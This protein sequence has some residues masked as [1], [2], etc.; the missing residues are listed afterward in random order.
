MQMVLRTL[1]FWHQHFDTLADQLVACVT[2]QSFGR[3]IDLNHDALLVYRATASGIAS[4]IEAD[5]R[6]SATI[7]G[8]DCMSFLNGT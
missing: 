6:V 5:S 7:F 2:E 1:T 8:S 4:R 3:G